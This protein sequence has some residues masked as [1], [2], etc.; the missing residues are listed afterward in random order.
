MRGVYISKISR[1]Q[2]RV[3]IYLLAPHKAIIRHIIT[4]QPMCTQNS[5]YCSGLYNFTHC[6][7][8]DR[9]KVFQIKTA[10]A[11]NTNR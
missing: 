2:R 8:L 3:C 11:K 1:P 7:L 5:D 10:L 9:G 4:I 6:Q